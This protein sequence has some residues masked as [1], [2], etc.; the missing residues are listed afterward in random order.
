MTGMRLS[1]HCTHR[2]RLDVPRAEVQKADCLDGSWRT[3]P[4]CT[5][6]GWTGKERC[7]ALPGRLHPA[8]RQPP[9]RDGFYARPDTG[10]LV[11]TCRL[12]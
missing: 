10:D 11:N 1:P 7:S 3:T 2:A 5:T 8:H 12:G 6:A 4:G 9:P